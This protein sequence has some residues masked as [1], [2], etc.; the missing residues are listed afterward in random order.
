MHDR[1]ARRKDALRIR[2]TGCIRQ[3]ADH[4]LLDFFGRIEAECGEV[5]NIQLD[6]LVAFFLHLLGLLQHRAANV[7]ADVGEFGGFLDVFHSMLPA[8]RLI[9][10]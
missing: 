6:D 2:V 9:A 5:A 4:V 8:R 10:C 1:L 7:V 3:V